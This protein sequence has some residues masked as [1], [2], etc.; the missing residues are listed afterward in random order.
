[1]LL[2]LVPTGETAWA[3]P[4]CSSGTPRRVLADVKPAP[5]EFSFEGLD[6]EDAAGIRD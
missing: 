6:D 3:P 1:M 2:Q 4:R 5:L